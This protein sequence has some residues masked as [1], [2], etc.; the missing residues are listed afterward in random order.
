[1]GWVR[2]W[3]G[4]ILYRFGLGAMFIVC[5]GFELDWGFRGGAWGCFIFQMKMNSLRS[6]TIF[7]IEK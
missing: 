3:V 2:G 4:R 6:D 5:F 1:M 7:F